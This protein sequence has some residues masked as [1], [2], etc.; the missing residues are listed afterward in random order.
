MLNLATGAQSSC[1]PTQGYGFRTC[2]LPAPIAVAAGESYS[3]SSSGSVELMRM[4]NAQR[5]M[6]PSIG[7]SD[8][9]LRACQSNPAPGTNAKDVPSLWA[10]P[11][12]ANFPSA[13]E[14]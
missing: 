14:H 12:S 10:G 11:L 7:T 9:E 1:T 4:D 13:G 2:T 5:V 8:G 6:F 3:V